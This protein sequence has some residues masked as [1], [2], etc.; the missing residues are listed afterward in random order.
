MILNPVEH[1]PQNRS[2]AAHAGS[3][4]LGV[5][6]YRTVFDAGAASGTKIHVDAPRALIDLHREISF[7]T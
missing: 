2:R 1:N 5:I 3:S 7:L 6:H 4:Y